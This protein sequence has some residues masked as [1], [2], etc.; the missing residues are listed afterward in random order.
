MFSRRQ[1]LAAAALPAALPLAPTAWAQ[2]N[3][4]RLVVGFAAGGAADFV[5]RQLAQN[6]QAELGATV[7]VD[8]RPGAGGRIAVDVARNAKADG[9]TLLV[10]PGS[11]LT[12]YPHVYDR[13][14]Y[15]PLRD[16]VPVAN[17]CAVP[18]SVN[19]GPGVPASVTT[20]KEFGQW[21]KAH[22]Q[23]AS[24]GSPGAGTTPHF[25]GAMFAAS[26]GVDYL[27][28]PYK[29]GS[30]ALQDVMGGQLTS[31][32]NVVSE[33]VPHAASPKLRVLA[34]SSPQR[35][36]QLPKVPTFT[37]LGMKELT[38]QE[39]IGLLA[40]KGTKPEVAARLHDAANRAFAQPAVQKA[41]AEMAFGVTTSTQAE[42]AQLLKGDLDKWGPVVRSTGF[43]AEA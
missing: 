26:A 3:V 14:S 24:Y 25:L 33:A 10:T 11:I 23:Q 39:W 7:V 41:L 27:H 12:I 29:G 13:L 5:A 43:K 1:F 36:A 22:P 40:P 34:V 38:S 2:S 32:F 21:L 9:L 30:L 42:F 35:I 28:V 16:L 17:L 31:S 18:Y 8:N 6:L 20:L 4:V 19:I 15:Q 37:E